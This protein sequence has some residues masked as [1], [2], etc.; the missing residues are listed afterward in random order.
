MDKGNAGFLNDADY[1]W[2]AQC[3][4]AILREEWVENQKDWYM[5]NLT[6]EIV[7]Q[8]LDESEPSLTM[9]DACKNEDF[10]LLGSCV[11]NRIETHCYVL[12]EIDYENKQT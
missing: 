12:S 7:N 1:E 5:K 6:V 11:V 3:S 4:R 2:E 10:K 8:A 9:V